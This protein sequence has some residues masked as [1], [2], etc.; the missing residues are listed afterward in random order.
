MKTEKSERKR[1]EWTM[2][3]YAGFQSLCQCMD[4]ADVII[5]RLPKGQEVNV[6]LDPET[7]ALFQAH[8]EKPDKG[9]AIPV[10]SVALYLEVANED[11]VDQLKALVTAIKGD[12]ITDLYDD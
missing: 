2:T 7:N 11:A 12:M 9:E 5:A 8:W 10:T 1:Y 4:K 3:Y 6:Y